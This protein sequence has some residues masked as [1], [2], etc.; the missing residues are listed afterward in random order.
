MS[1]ALTEAVLNTAGE[2]IER[3]GLRAYVQVFWPW[4]EPG[5]QYVDG[6]H[7]H[8]L[9]DWCTEAFIHRSIKRSVVNLPPRMLKSTIFS[10]FGQSYAW[11]KDPTHRFLSASYDLGLVERDAARIVDVINSPLHQA[12]Y[13]HVRLPTVHAR[14]KLVT[15]SGGRRLGTSPKARGLGWGSQTQVI[16]DPIKL[17][18]VNS[19]KDRDYVLQWITQT[20]ANRIDGPPDNFVRLLTMQRLHELDPSGVLT[21]LG[22]ESLVLPMGVR[23]PRGKFVEVMFPQLW[24]IDSVNDLAEEMSSERAVSSQ[25]QQDPMPSTGSFVERDWIKWFD[26]L[27]DRHEALRWAQMWDLNFKG[28]SEAQSRVAGILYF[29]REGNVYIWDAYAKHITYPQTRE[30]LLARNVPGTEWGRAGAVNV[31]DAANGP[32]LMAD[33][34]HVDSRMPGAEARRLLAGKLRPKHP[35]RLSK[36]ERVKLQ[37][38]KIRAGRLLIRSGLTELVNELCGFPT[39]KYNDLTDCV[40]SALEMLDSGKLLQHSHTLERIQ[41]QRRHNK[42][43]L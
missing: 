31:E 20:M 27:P 1:E 16:D 40:T 22:W 39:A 13:P 34:R 15:T 42:W 2:R 29:V 11:T 18:S 38:D 3:D 14:K 10:V 23:D 36:E 32:A 8:L 35:G 5:T 28:T 33:L 26:V 21:D 6:D 24:S 41:A 19:E 9:C 4:A 25:L 12:L 37:S 7:V 17:S 30:E 43:R